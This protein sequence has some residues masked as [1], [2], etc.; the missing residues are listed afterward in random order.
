VTPDEFRQRFPEFAGADTTRLQRLIDDATPHLDVDRWGD[1]YIQGLSY[2]VAHYAAMT[3]AMSRRQLVNDPEDDAIM[4][5]A[6]DSEIKWSEKVAVLQITKSTLVSTPY[7]QQ[8]MTLR[9][10]IGLGGVS[11]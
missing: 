4:K 7:G 1:F 8:Y 9:K 10:L 3:A 11:V 5:K 2:L 6:G